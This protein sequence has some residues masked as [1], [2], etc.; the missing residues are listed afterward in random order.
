MIPAG[1]GAPALVDLYDA[2]LFDLDGVVYLGPVAVAGA[3][4]GI[5]ELRARGSRLGFVTNNAARPP[6]ASPCCP[7]RPAPPR[8]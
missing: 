4:E 6:A 2:A 7:S 3:V 5:A 8:R 1:S